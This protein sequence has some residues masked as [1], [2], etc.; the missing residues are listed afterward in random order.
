MSSSLFRAKCLQLVTAVAALV[1]CTLALSTGQGL[2][3]ANVHILSFTAGGFVYI[4]T[5]SVLPELLESAATPKQSAMELLAMLVGIGF[6]V[7]AAQFE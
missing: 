2:D 3:T 1:G 7:L 6:M 4:A 5:V